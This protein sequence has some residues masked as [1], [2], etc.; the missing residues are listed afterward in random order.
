MRQ[1]NKLHP[2]V[3]PHCSLYCPLWHTFSLS[4]VE[5]H[6]S[7]FHSSK[8]FP[9]SLQTQN[10]TPIQ[11]FILRFTKSS[12]VE[13]VLHEKSILAKK[14]IVCVIFPTLSIYCYMD[15][16]GN[17]WQWEIPPFSQL[18]Y[19]NVIKI[20]PSKHF[21]RTM[22]RFRQNL[23]QPIFCMKNNVPHRHKK[24]ASHWIACSLSAVLL[25]PS[26]NSPP[27]G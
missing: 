12:L 6:I 25:F 9:L 7:S 14:S 13:R 17:L 2:N 1:S 18:V 22:A 26:C 8:P 27:F 23:N 24:T 16:S 19:G 20:L 11:R 21:Q 10:Q 3:Y 15:F 4:H 5:T